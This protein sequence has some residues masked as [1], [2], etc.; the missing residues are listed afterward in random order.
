VVV[1]YFVSP[2]VPPRSMRWEIASKFQYESTPRVKMAVGE[3]VIDPGDLPRLRAAFERGGQQALSEALPERYVTSLSATGTVEDVRARV[4][5]YRRA[6]VDLPL[7]RPSA[8]HQLPRLLA[9][10]R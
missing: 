1:D 6:G 9:A 2:P 7:V 5:E 8:P 3:P 4:A 10:S